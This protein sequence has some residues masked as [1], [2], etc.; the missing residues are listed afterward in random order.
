MTRCSLRSSKQKRGYA[1]RSGVEQS[2]KTTST[3]G[4]SKQLTTGSAASS[5]KAKSGS[6]TQR[7]SKNRYLTQIAIDAQ[8]SYSP[9]SGPSPRRSASL[10]SSSDSERSSDARTS[11]STGSGSSSDSDGQGHQCA[12]CFATFTRKDSLKR[13]VESIHEYVHHCFILYR[14]LLMPNRGI[15]LFHCSFCP[16]TSRQPYNVKIH[17]RL[18]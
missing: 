16:H 17:E 4:P 18:Q 12:E 8:H 6:T 5:S 10:S 14:S 15:L 1:L 11:S 7:L 13:H 9:R 3:L 2:R